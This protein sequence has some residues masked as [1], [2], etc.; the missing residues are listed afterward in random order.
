MDVLG[1][2]NLKKLCRVLG[3]TEPQLTGEERLPEG[4]Q[5]DLPLHQFSVRLSSKSRLN[6]ELI[7][8]Q[9]GISKEQLVEAAPLLFMVLAR[10]SLAWREEQLDGLLNAVQVFRESGAGFM[11]DEAREALEETAEECEREI[12]A[13]RDEEILA[14]SSTDAELGVSFSNRFADYLIGTAKPGD[15]AFG[16]LGPISVFPDYLVCPE[17]LRAIC[18]GENAAQMPRAA[19]SLV[20]G[21]VT[22]AEIPEELCDPERM[23]DR[24]EWLAKFAPELTSGA[25]YKFEKNEIPSITFF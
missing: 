18:G 24:S 2:E 3:V 17:A 23:E 9:Y 4:S 21:K 15:V 1:F 19:V 6:Y 16:L 20:T 12:Q 11:G 10:K 8:A 5:G 25:Q 13:V 7:T 22:I 14:P